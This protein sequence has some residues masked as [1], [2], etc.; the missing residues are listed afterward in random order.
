VRRD[1]VSVFP[2]AAEFRAW[3]AA[4]HDSTPELWVG[5]Y[6][7]G[8]GKAS[9]TY[10]EAVDEALS[11]GWIDG[12]TRRIDDAIYANRFTPRRPRSTWSA[13]MVARFEAL[14][15]QGRVHPAGLRAFEARSASNTGIY[16]YENAPRELP[17]DY[18]ARLRANPGAWRY[19]QARPAGYRRT[20]SFWVM[21]A[22][23]AET[24]ERRLVRLIE[25]CAQ[26]RPIKP[27]SY[28]QP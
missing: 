5:Y 24:R 26:G 4:N 23:R 12:I 2:T 10:P 7:K 3:L 8:V 19:W 16:S 13:T 18:E 25:D 17:P 15:R 6:K 28:G 9:M 27:L 22:K 21:S 14:R 1:E 11:F 20:A